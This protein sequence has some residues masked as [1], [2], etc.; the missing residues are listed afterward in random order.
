MRPL[1]VVLRQNYP[2][3]EKREVLYPQLG[4]D[5]LVSKPAFMDTCAVRVSVALLRSGVVIPGAWLKVSAGPLKN[6][7]VQPRQG[8]LSRALVRIWGKP[9]AYKGIMTAHDGIGNR[10][11][12][13]SF[14]GIYGAQGDGGHIDLVRPV[15][16]RVHECARSCFF[17]ARE[18]WFW[19]LR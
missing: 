19:E 11:G 6:Q 12:V 13:I 2:K 7:L 16:D 4:W 17:T 14:F 3:S 15:G 18:I 1:F 8:D 5:D 10:S 9:E